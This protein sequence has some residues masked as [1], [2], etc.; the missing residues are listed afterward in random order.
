MK[1]P[2][3]H[4]NVDH[5]E[6]EADVAASSAEQD[7]EERKRSNTQELARKFETG[8]VRVLRGHASVFACLSARCEFA[9]VKGSQQIRTAS[10]YH[11]LDVVRS[12]LDLACSSRAPAVG[13][14][15]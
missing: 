6:V 3:L 1:H 13:G 15:R 4:V 9:G 7:A 12:L 14:G 10:D 11:D 8:G 5:Q 2:P